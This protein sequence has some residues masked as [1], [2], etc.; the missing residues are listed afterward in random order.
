M[1]SF[2]RAMG[3]HHAL[4]SDAHTQ[5]VLAGADAHAIATW[6]DVCDRVETKLDRGHDA[7]PVGT[8]LKAP[9]LRRP[10]SR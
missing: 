5:F 3:K 10:R 4:P 2:G 6:L 1:S 7:V 8:T 9:F